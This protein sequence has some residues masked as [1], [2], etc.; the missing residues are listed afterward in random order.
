[1]LLNNFFA[2][3]R[4][5]STFV[6]GYILFGA[7]FS[8]LIVPVYA[9]LVKIAE[10]YGYPKDLRTQGLISGLFSCVYSLG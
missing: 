8:G 10:T 3:Y 2:C 5:L 4:R 6:G 9:E 7:S 1:M